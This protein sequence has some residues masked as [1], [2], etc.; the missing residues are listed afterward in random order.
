[1]S[2]A[3]VIKDYFRAIETGDL[4]GML[5]CYAPDAIQI[6]L[7]NLL[8]IKGDRRSVS[9]LKRDFEKG[10]KLL[11]SQSYEILSLIDDADRV[12]VEVLWR[13]TLAIP[14]KSLRE[15]D[16]MK[17]H[18]AI[19]FEFKDGLIVTQKNYDCFDSF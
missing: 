15:G 13:G 1:M 4:E 12:S 16:Q 6:E 18:S 3:T 17:A 8:K 7:P 19:F 9:D 2:K 14:I 5:K 11:L 10:A